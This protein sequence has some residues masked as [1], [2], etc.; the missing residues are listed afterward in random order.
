MCQKGNFQPPVT[1][2]LQ[3]FFAF[4]FLTRLNPREV[5]S[6]WQNHGIMNC[7]LCNRPAYHQVEKWNESR[8]QTSSSDPASLHEMVLFDSMVSKF[9]YA[10]DSVSLSNQNLQADE[11]PVCR[12][13]SPNTCQG[14]LQAPQHPPALD[15][16]RRP[17]LNFFPDKKKQNVINCIIQLKNQA[18]TFLTCSNSAPLG[19][20]FV[21]FAAFAAL[22]PCPDLRFMAIASDSLCCK[23]TWDLDPSNTASG[24]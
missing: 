21:V 9:S 22:P 23:Q 4:C 10:L 16:W 19:A 5:S 14:P 1:L 2:K 13:S 20:A 18:V 24:N 7:E 3:N 11:A 15:E 6:L 12:T 8:M 17:G